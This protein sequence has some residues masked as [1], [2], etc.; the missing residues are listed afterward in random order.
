MIRASHGSML[1]E[2]VTGV[3][4]QFRS[5][6]RILGWDLWNEPDN[7]ATVYRTVERPDKDDLVAGLL[8]QVFEWARA[9]DPVQ[10]LTSG[11]WQGDW[12]DPSRRSPIAGIQLDNSDVISFHSYADP[13]D[14]EGRIAELDADAATDPLHR[15]PGAHAGQQRRGG[16]SG[17][18]AARR[19]RVQL[20][21][22]R[23][24][25]SDVSAVGFLGPPGPRPEGVVQ[26]PAAGSTGGPIGTARSA[27]CAGR[28]PAT[29]RQVGGRD[30]G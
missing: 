3:L 9:V 15:V 10:P 26:R 14:F 1:K 27:P 21:S 11:V 6:D 20:G 8:P 17:G 28:D 4:S 30:R 22:G 16:P 2:Y 29:S 25:D 19:C 7:P 18:G 5:D 13:V 24:E 23:G 12:A